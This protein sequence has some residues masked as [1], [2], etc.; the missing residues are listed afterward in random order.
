MAFRVRGRLADGLGWGW[1]L[2]KQRPDRIPDPS[3]GPPARACSQALDASGYQRT[4]VSS[5]HTESVVLIHSWLPCVFGA[6]G[7]VVVSALP[8]PPH[9]FAPVLG[10]DLQQVGDRGGIP[11]VSLLCWGRLGGAGRVVSVGPA[12]VK[13]VPAWDPRV[14]PPAAGPQQG[15]EF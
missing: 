3:P 6:N 13:E 2:Q 7:V 5:V 12:G 15:P 10:A 14:S 8:P 1:G 9:P 4:S 11:G